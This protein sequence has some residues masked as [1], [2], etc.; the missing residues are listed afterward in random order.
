MNI[1]INSH[2]KEVSREDATQ[3]TRHFSGADD[4]FNEHVT[5]TIKQIKCDKTSDAS[6]K[7]KRAI[8]EKKEDF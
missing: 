6:K 8:L 4:D 7:D 3:A 1:R 5:F 2:K